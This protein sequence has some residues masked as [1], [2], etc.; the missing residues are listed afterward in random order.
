MVVCQYTNVGDVVLNPHSH[1]NRRH[2]TILGCWGYEYTHL[3]RA[4]ALM[5][6]HRARFRW[7][8]LVTC[9][10]PLARADEALDDMEAMRVT[11]A[12]IRPGS[13]G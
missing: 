10:Y 13:R 8:A 12:L 5:A 7:S 6:K 2:A 1:I 4:L 9:E 11:K 3:H